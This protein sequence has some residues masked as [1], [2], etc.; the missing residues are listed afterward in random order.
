M[1]FACYFNSY[2][3]TAS[4]NNVPNSVSSCDTSMNS[5]ASI[6]SL[7]NV[8]LCNK[9]INKI[10]LYHRR[11]GHPNQQIL[12]HLL[13]N[14]HDINLSSISVNQT[15]KHICEAC[16]TG[17]NHKIDFPAKETKTTKIHELIHTDLQGPSLVLSRDALTYHLSFVDDFSRY[18]WIYP[19]KLKL[20][21]L[22]VFELFKLQVENQFDTIIKA[23]QSNW[24]GEYISFISF[25][26]KSG[27]IFRHY[28]PYTYY[29]NGLVQR[30]HRHIIELGVILLAQAKLPF[31]F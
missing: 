25:L 9:Q 13:K 10:V 26:N 11:F 17:K 3:Q 21:A 19:L 4:Q 20:E 27:I 7:N 28:C 31:K 16:Q 22:E 1:L 14:V 2:V 12:M 8:T 30:K 15:L 18:T 24:G 6:E 5:H 23:L 29:Q